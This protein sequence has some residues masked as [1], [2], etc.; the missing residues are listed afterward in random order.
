MTAVVTVIVVILIMKQ[1]RGDNKGKD[2]KQQKLRRQCRWN[3]WTQVVNA[4]WKY[5]H[6]QQR[7]REK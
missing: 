6:K 1:K 3:G 5:K 2:I 4:A 7:V